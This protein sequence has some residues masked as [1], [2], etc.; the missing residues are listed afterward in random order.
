MVPLKDNFYEYWKEHLLNIYFEDITRTAS[1]EC[2][3]F[4]KF[5]DQKNIEKKF[6]S[7][8]DYLLKAFAIEIISRLPKY[9]A[10]SSFRKK[11]FG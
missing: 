8:L 9:N 6:K 7:F 1:S 11:D 5:E 3:I 2:C 4:R 10:G